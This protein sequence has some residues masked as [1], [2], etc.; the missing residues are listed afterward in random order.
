MSAE[1]DT[2]EK[3]E[4]VVVEVGTAIGKQE[5]LPT[6]PMDEVPRD[7]DD[8]LKAAMLEEMSSVPLSGGSKST[9]P[10]ASTTAAE[11]SVIAGGIDKAI[12]LL[13]EEDGGQLRRSKNELKPEQ[14]ASLGVNFEVVMLMRQGLSAEAAVKKLGL[15]KTGSWARKLLKRYMDGGQRVEALM[16]GRWQNARKTVICGDVQKILLGWYFSGPAAGPR[17]VWELTIETCKQR[18][19]PEPGYEAVKDYI[20]KLP[21]SYQLLRQGRPGEDRW[22]RTAAPVMPYENTLYSNQR[23]QADNSLLPNWLKRQKEVK[24]TV[25]GKEIT[26]TKWVVYR[27]WLSLYLDVHSRSIPA[28]IVSRKT[29]D[30]MTSLLLMALAVKEKKN[31]K[32]RNRGLPDIVQP[33]NG[34][35]FKSNAVRGSFARLHI[36]LDYDPPHCPNRKGKI[37]RIFR[38]IKTGLMRKLPGHAAAIGRSEAAAQKYCDKNPHELLTIEQ[39][40]K[41]IEAWVVD[42]YHQRTH[43]TTKRKPVELY[44]ETL[45][46][47]EPERDTDLDTL[48]LKSDEMRVITNVGVRFT[49][50]RFKGRYWS[51]EITDLAGRNVEVRYNPE[52]LQSILLYDVSTDKFLCEVWLMGNKDSRFTEEDVVAY[53]NGLVKG[54]KKRMQ[55]F[56]AE[57]QEGDR[58]SADK[59]EWN[60]AR[61]IHNALLNEADS[62]GVSEIEDNVDEDDSDAMDDELQEFFKKQDRGE[63]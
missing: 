61:R 62:N 43:S 49:T 41:L 23:W 38:T 24:M 54:L 32:W 26:L 39:L 11:D 37:E 13:V 63:I 10:A 52:D 14:I 6:L 28:F 47:R 59:E 12:D 56:R 45:R 33:D 19:L 34:S 4:M 16:D 7:G 40:R 18:E 36:R 1:I 9:P 31:R 25:D 5:K 51:P 53:R 15:K 60:E 27:P 35:D 20:K 21:L 48:L 22:R 42:G 58:P 2:N 30:A 57:V 46:L 3:E 50:G 29:P 17:A 8:A 44:E 55:E